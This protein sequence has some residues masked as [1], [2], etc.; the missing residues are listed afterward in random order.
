MS[1]K[2]KKGDDYSSGGGGGGGAGV[3]FIINK[4]KRSKW[5]EDFSVQ[6]VL[7][8]SAAQ[9]IQIWNKCML[10]EVGA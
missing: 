3:W 8:T 4:N 7:Q 5:T 10:N 9:W 6:S 1:K 2:T